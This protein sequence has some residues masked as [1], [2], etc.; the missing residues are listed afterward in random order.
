L[1]RVLRLMDGSYAGFCAEELS[2]W[3][4]GRHHMPTCVCAELSFS[5]APGESF[6]KQ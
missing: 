2:A 6:V 5:I 1:S 3:V 4:P